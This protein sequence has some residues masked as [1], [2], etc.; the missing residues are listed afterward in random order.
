MTG[1]TFGVGAGLALAAIA[2]AFGFWGF[3]LA[4]VF[5]TIGGVA[6]AAA[7]GRLDL[8]AVADAARGRRGL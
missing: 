6:G 5:A 3:L 2:L 7:S 4:V 1:V 8:R